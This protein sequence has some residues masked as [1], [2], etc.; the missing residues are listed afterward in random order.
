MI[1]WIEAHLVLILAVSTVV[2]LNSIAA[3][4]PLSNHPVTNIARWV[5]RGCG[6]A[7][8]LILL[9]ATPFLV[10]AGSQNWDPENDLAYG[11]LVIIAAAF[12]AALFSFFAFPIAFYRMFR[13]RS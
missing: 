9:V 3:Y 6:F 1:G 12:I 10:V 8:S 2:S 4:F 11:G 5:V 13:L 7:A